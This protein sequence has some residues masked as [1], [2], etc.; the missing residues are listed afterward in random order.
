MSI[1]I[2]QVIFTITSGGGRTLAI[3]QR[4]FG[5]GGYRNIVAQDC[6]Y[7]ERFNAGC[8]QQTHEQGMDGFHIDLRFI[9]TDK[10]E[11]ASSFHSPDSMIPFIGNL[12]FA[13]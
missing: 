8:Q 9:G 7:T 4:C 10:D 12:Y 6:F 2:V 3:W 5:S 13:A 11:L 1:L